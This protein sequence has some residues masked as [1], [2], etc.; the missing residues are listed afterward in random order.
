QTKLLNNVAYLVPH[1]NIRSL[2]MGF[3]EREAS[4][5][6]M[7]EMRK[8]A[9]KAMKEGAIGF[10]TGLIYPPNVFSNTQE[11]IEI[12]KGV[13][14]YDG[15]F[16]VHVRNESTRLLEALDEVIEVSKKSG[17][18]LHVSHFKSM[19]LKN[20]YKYDLALEKMQTAREKGVEV[21]FDQYPYAASSTVFHSILPPWAHSGGTNKML[22]H[23]TKEESRNKIKEDLKNNEDYENHVLNCGWDKIVIANVEKNK[24]IE[25]KSV[26]EISNLWDKS[27]EDAAMD[28]LLE[29]Q[30]NVTMI[31][32]WGKEKDIEKAMRSPLL[33]VGSDGIF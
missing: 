25:N 20:S 30:G 24:D 4:N 28:L 1:G 26:L 9:E 15:C 11:L 16:V 2:V 22:E 6:E 19:G 5:E 31:C 21:T 14:K 10:S 23:L 8:Q 29:E 32:H 27:P 7:T 3:E 33:I 18:R 12:C 13:A 17:V